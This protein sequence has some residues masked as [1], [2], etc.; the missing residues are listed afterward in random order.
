MEIAPTSGSKKENKFWIVQ[1][2]DAK[3]TTYII[4]GHKNLVTFAKEHGLQKQ[5]LERV[6]AGERRHHKQWLVEEFITKKRL[7]P[8]EMEASMMDPNVICNSLVLFGENENEN[9]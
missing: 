3:K 1:R 4:F 5:A 7:V 9:I 6:G 2:P 8:S